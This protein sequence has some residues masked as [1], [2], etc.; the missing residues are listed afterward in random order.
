VTNSDPPVFT[1]FMRDITDRKLVEEAMREREARY[2]F[3][4]E[5]T[6]VA[7]WEEDFTEVQKTIEDL[8]SQGIT[9]LRRHL[10][11]QA[12]LTR[13]IMASVRVLDVNQQSLVMFGAAGKEE[14]KQSLDRI[15]LPE[16]LPLFIEEA[17]ALAEGQSYFEGETTVQ[18]L[19]GEKRDILVTIHFPEA[20]GRLDHTLVSMID[21]TA[22]RQAEVSVLRSQTQLA[23]IINS[24]M[25]AII[26]IDEN[27]RILIFNP[28]AEKMFQ[29][30][31]DKV[32]GKPL[33]L[34]IPERFHALH[35]KDVRAFGRSSVTKRTMGRLD[36]VQGLRLNG[37]EFPME[38]S[39]SQ[40]EIR[41]RKIYTA[42]LRDITERKQA[43]DELNRLNNDLEKRVAERTSQLASA[44]RELEAFSYS[45]SHDLRAPLRSIDGF[46]QALLEDFSDQIPAEGRGHL[47]RVRA[48]AQ[49]MAV[50]IDDLLALSRVTRTP[51]ERKPVD[52]SALAGKILTELQL[53]QPGRQVSV[54]IAPGL[55]VNGDENLLRIA[56][57]NLLS[58]AWKFTSK[59]DSALI[60]FGAQD[61]TGERVFFVRDNGS[62]F[63]MTYVHKLFGAFQRLHSSDDFPGTGIGLATVQRI[64]TK[65]GGRVWAEGERDKGATFYFK[66]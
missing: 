55:T 14:L 21:I 7:I 64:F 48:A 38:A 42:I 65:H 39:I 36:A 16:T 63:D 49:R 57:Y 4:F 44:I 11:E 45:V 31:A 66:L 61:G 51:V 40:I 46:S 52:L 2:R 32:I 1:V 10:A 33:T 13:Q 18:T 26:S 3:I 58:N 29:R 60:E 56:L 5:S 24:A 25:D 22:R 59:K 28:A 54:S 50:L 47:D 35:E 12:E 27:Q 34:L 30:F 19:Q 9:D 17:A 15:F 37:Q 23:G 20:G 62:G 8:K 41:G 43:E 53:E 6:P